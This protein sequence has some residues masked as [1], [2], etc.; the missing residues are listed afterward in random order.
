MKRKSL[1]KQKENINEQI[2]DGVTPKEIELYFGDYN[3]N[4]FLTCVIIGLSKENENF[5]DFLSSSLGYKILTENKITIY[6][7]TGNVYF[8][9]TNS[10]ESL[11]AF[12]TTQQGEK[13]K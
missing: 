10:N 5:V 8:D 7:E 9:K 13:K 4:F 2:N 11:Y 12:F 3:K 1:K 6:T